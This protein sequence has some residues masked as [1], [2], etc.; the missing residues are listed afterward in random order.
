MSERNAFRAAGQVVAALE[1]GLAIRCVDTDGIEFEGEDRPGIPSR[2]DALA[3][4]AV[5]LA[6]IAAVDK[7]RFG[8]PPPGTG[9]WP[10]THWQFTRSQRDDLSKVVELV[11]AID[12]DG[13]RDV[14]YLGWIQAFDFVA[15]AANWKTIEFFAT[16]VAHSPVDGISIRYIVDDA[17]GAPKSRPPG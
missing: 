5:G 10:V 4:I 1:E 16:V 2:L 8:V 11:D 17:V 15:E 6:G 12:P 14:L 9:R 3:Q 7:Y 13:E